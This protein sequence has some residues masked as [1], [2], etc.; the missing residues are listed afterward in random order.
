VNF[1]PFDVVVVPFPFT[2]KPTTKRR[3]ALIVS[4]AGFNAAHDQL[5]LAMITTARQSDWPSDVPLQEWNSA[6]L[7]VP[8]RIR[9]KLFTLEKAMIIK[10][11]GSLTDRD[12]VA[13]RSGLSEWI[14]INR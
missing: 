14:A 11:A 10:R 1:E 7:S 4:S 9:F 13:V 6:G 12:R 8:C 3:P 2:D 5:V